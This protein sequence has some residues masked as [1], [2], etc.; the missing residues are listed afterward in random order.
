MLKN[1]VSGIS[2]VPFPSTFHYTYTHPRHYVEVI[3]SYIQ[4]EL[5]FFN[6]ITQIR[7]EYDPWLKQAGAQNKFSAVSLQGTLS[8][9]LQEVRMC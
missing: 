7:A 8:D 2:N 4:L 3:V 5:E 9:T 1:T 6:F